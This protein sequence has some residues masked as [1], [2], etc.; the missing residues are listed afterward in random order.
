MKRPWLI[1]LAALV[2]A[3]LVVNSSG[4]AYYF[5]VFY[6]TSSGPF[7]QPIVEKFALNSL[8]NNTVPFFISDSG[9]DFLAPG[10]SFQAIIGEIRGAA[11][12]WSNVSSSQLRLGYGGLFTAGTASESSPGIDIEFSD[13]IPPGLVAIGAPQVTGNLGY[14]SGSLIVPIV[15]AKIYLP[16]DLTQ[17]PTY[18][19]FPSYSEPFFVTIVHEFGHT[20]G[21]QH[22]LTSGVMSTL[23]TSAASK[24][25]PLGTDDIAGISVLYPSD[26]YLQTVG[27]ISGRVTLGSNG[28]NLASVVALSPSNP[29]ISILTNPDGSYRMDGVPPGQYFVYT[30]P[31]PPALYGESSP[32]NI[33]Y[34]TDVNGN[35]MA[36][37][38]TA[39]ATQFFTGNL[40]ENLGGTRD[41]TQALS[42]PVFAATLTSGVDFHVSA[43][44]SQAVYAVRTYGFSQTNVAEASP[45]LTKGQSTP[46]PVAASGAGLLQKD[47]VVT[48]GLSV[49]VLGTA[50]AASNLRPYPPPTPYIAVDVQVNI[51]AGEGPKHLL[52][53]T[54]SDLYVLPAA[55]SVVFNAPPSITSVTSQLDVNEKRIVLIGGTGFFPDKNT[56]TSILFDGQPGIIQGVTKDGRLIVT[57]PPAAGGYTATVVAL[58]SDGQSS[59]FLKPTPP[60]FTY[61]GGGIASLT[62]T[63]KVL[64]AGSDTTVDIVGSNSNFIDGQTVVGFGTSDVVVKKVTVLSPT[65]L[66]V[67]VA[68]NVTVATS[69]INV[70]TGLGVISQSQGNRVTTANP[71]H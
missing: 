43:R 41:A 19:N 9:P 62:V 30:H 48:P 36:L 55:F 13:N 29:A 65:H 40:P 46:A 3:C 56:N 14:G 8:V 54:P 18:G 22:T 31:L 58:N 33:V 6:N 5:Y 35:S 50:A 25:S 49:A 52:F 37:N 63:P 68:P 20:L 47:N 64:V 17:V 66:S 27:S 26:D 16:R 1:R 7:N 38:Y 70:T 59:L 24:A 34:P 32:D 51:T 10:D 45:P 11:A 60:T 15:R 4:W 44:A 53:S 67:L 61:D 23:W 69:G 39:F 12:V 2:I 71:K 28:L 42:I 21:L 57:P